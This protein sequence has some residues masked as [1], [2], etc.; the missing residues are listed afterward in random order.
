MYKNSDLL[1]PLSSFWKNNISVKK[2]SRVPTIL[3]YVGVMWHLLIPINI[4][5]NILMSFY[6]DNCAIALWSLNKIL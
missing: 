3:W 1:A 4:S 6:A 2:E 5:R